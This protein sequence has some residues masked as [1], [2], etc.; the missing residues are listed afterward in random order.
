MDIKTY[1]AS[2]ILELYVYGSLSEEENT[3]VYKV[4][5][6]Y[7]EAVRE[8][9]RIEKALQQLSGGAAPTSTASTY[10]KIKDQIES[11]N[12]NDVIPITRKRNNIPAYI[13]WAASVALLIGLFVQFNKNRTLQQQLVTFQTEK[14]LLEGKINVT[15]ED[16]SKTK[17]LLSILRN[18]DIIQ[19]PLQA[20]QIDPTAY[21]AVYWDKDKQTAYID[22][23]GLPT[24]PPGKVYQVWSLKLDPLTPT[25]MGTLDEFNK[26]DTKIFM[27]TNPNKSE[28]FGI[29]LEPEGGSE[30]PTMEQ[31]YTLGTVAS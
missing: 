28:A 12:T 19:V 25:S 23:A 18:K 2:G 3:E 17:S 9:D 8:V 7:P 30:S 27:L 10:I 24:P 29:T 22:V 20:Q 26:D 16:L 13:G 1:I 21:A 31:L 15:E 6:K 4:L 5:Q 14:I 11:T